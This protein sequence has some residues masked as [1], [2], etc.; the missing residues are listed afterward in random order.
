MKGLARC[1]CIAAEHSN[2]MWNL[3]FKK[4]RGGVRER[5]EREGR[6][7]KCEDPMGYRESCAL[8][9]SPDNHRPVKHMKHSMIR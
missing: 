5:G 3:E 4:G 6:M 1:Y 8:C 2:S 9:T 7:Y